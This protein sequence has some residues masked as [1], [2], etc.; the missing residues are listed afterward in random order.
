[1]RASG[2]L[3]ITGDL[4]ARRSLKRAAALARFAHATIYLAPPPNLGN[5]DARMKRWLA[6]TRPNPRVS[7]RNISATRRRLIGTR[8]PHGLRNAYVSTTGV[9]GD[10]A[11]DWVSETS[12][13]RANSARSKR[14]VAAESRLRRVRYSRASV[15][16][17]PGIYA[18]TRLPVERL[19]ERV[20]ALVANE[21]VFTNHIHAND[22][23][24]A[25]WLALFRGKPQRTYN[26]VDDAT[27]K[28]GEYFDC[29]ADALALPRPPRLTRTEL[30]QR[31]TPMMLSFM[32]ESRRIRNDRMKHELRARLQYATPKVMLDAMKP[33]AALQRSP[34]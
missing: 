30:A 10:R 3:P 22:F 28:M 20:P 16:R 8:N 12:A 4:D 25:I 18:E 32:A 17:A 26:I 15:L 6:A 11:G 1:M 24:H 19:R 14:R 5:D 34:L 7:R 27:L 21:D 13:L 9:Y 2:I 33:E 23:A 31:V 29:V